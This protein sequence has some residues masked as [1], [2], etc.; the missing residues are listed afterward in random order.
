MK[1]LLTLSFVLIAFSVSGCS[2]YSEKKAPCGNKKTASL[3]S[4]PC[5]PLPINVAL[6]NDQKSKDHS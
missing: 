5:D 1:K 2:H 6:L 4:N 3:S